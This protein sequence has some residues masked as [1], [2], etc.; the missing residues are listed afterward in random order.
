MREPA[1]LSVISLQTSI[2]VEYHRLAI[3]VSSKEG[4]QVDRPLEHE[5]ACLIELSHCSQLKEN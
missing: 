4:A 3:N 5:R 2:T 1:I